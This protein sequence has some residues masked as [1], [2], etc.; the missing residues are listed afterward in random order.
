MSGGSIRGASQALQLSL[1]SL[2]KIVFSISFLLEN[3][4]SDMPTSVF[5]LTDV[6]CSSWERL[7]FVTD[8]ERMDKKVIG[9]VKN[10]IKNALTGF[11]VKWI[12]DNMPT[13]IIPIPWNSS[14]KNVIKF[15][16]APNSIPAIYLVEP[17]TLQDQNTYLGCSEINSGFGKRNFKSACGFQ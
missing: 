8:E 2:P 17:V 5:L 1:H 6:S 7:Q 3:T 4:R 14:E 13:S 16:Q 9:M 10:A 11:K 12:D 15:C